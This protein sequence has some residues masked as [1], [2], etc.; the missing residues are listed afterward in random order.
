MKKLLITACSF[1]AL[2]SLYSFLTDIN[3]SFK[4]QAVTGSKQIFVNS[5]RGIDNASGKL[6]P[7][8]FRKRTNDSIF[9]GFQMFSFDFDKGVV[10]YDYL[11]NV[12]DSIVSKD[13]E[14]KIELVKSDGHFAVF[15]F[16]DPTK[17]ISP[18]NE[19]FFIVNLEDNLKFPMLQVLW[20]ENDKWIGTYSIDNRDFNELFNDSQNHIFRDR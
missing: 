14:L 16:N 9:E 2:F 8:S 1:V 15:K 5:Y 11:E 13:C 3:N 20:N 12:N 7:Y 10:L 17:L 6:S 18:I 19:K 4:V